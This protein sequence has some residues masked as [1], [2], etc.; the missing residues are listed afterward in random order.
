MPQN[1]SFLR[2]VPPLFFIGALGAGAC[3]I[4]G[5]PDATAPA[6]EPEARA[7]LAAV[8]D[9]APFAPTYFLRDGAR[10]C[11]T[12]TADGYSLVLCE[13]ADLEAKMPGEIARYGRVR[14]L[15]A[16]AVPSPEALAQ[17]GYLL[18]TYRVEGSRKARYL[19]QN[20]Y[21]KPKGGTTPRELEAWLRRNGLELEA[22][23][24]VRDWVYVRTRENPI[25]KARALV[26][27][28]EAEASEPSFFVATA[29][30]GG[31]PPLAPNDPYFHDQWNLH[32]DG[33]FTT[34]DGKATIKGSDQPHI[35]QAWQL[36]AQ[37]GLAKGASDVGK[38]VRLGIIDDGFDLEHEDLKG[39]F[40]ASQNFGSAL[41]A[42]N[43]FNAT[44]PK[45]FHGTLVTGI[46]AAAAD[47]GV[48]LA[49][50]CPGCRIIAARMSASVP[51]G[52]TPDQYYDQIFTWVMSQNPDVIN[53]SWGPDDTV[54]K[55]YY[56]ALVQD[57]TTKGRGGKGTVIVFASGNSGEDFAWNALASNPRS[58][59]VGASDSTGKRYGFSNFG[60]GLDVLAPTSGG[61]KSS[62]Y[63]DR[64]WST[65]NFVS[66]ACLKPGQQPSSSC[67]DAAGWTPQSPVAGGDGWWG[68]YSYRFSHTSSA[69]PLVSGVVGVML[70]AN[71]S[72][73]V[74][75]VNVIF[76]E[77]ADRVSLTEAAYDE[78]GFS[79][80]Y[81]YGRVNA[82]RALARAYELSGHT[83]DEATKAAIDEASP[84]TRASCWGGVTGAT[85]AASTGAGGIM[86]AASAGSGGVTSAASTGAGNAG[87]TSASAG[88]GG[89][90]GDGS[91]GQGEGGKDPGAEGGCAV[92]AAPSGGPSAWLLL[93]GL[94]LVHRRRRRAD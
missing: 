56:D 48:G 30:Y 12:P 15:D 24:H 86:S 54:A 44:S 14:L 59:T 1:Q 60:K 83:I 41:P 55:S 7:P 43:L 19:T 52:M 16:R 35:A 20:L 21:V 68:K 75:D 84:C 51:M 90:S 49:G 3:A 62:L 87:A 71:P 26:A 27:S 11:A 79:A 39:K 73:T 18:P 37:F 5:A 57:I 25:D 69:A 8:S 91:G 33:P 45:D 66:P 89:D 80:N 2:N 65:D 34:Q 10:V 42:G 74:D 81:G 22:R 70:H 46:A 85:S 29:L 76:H 94:P 77:T 40:I 93:L 9:S 88:A 4:D 92:T 50:A 72:L 82:L 78:S 17:E 13:G 6:S 63:V 67:S 64:I 53:C 28:G 61:E 38:A 32:S 58:I 47:N 36:L 23:L 31:I